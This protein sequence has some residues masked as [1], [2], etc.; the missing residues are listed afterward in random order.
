[1][2]PFLPREEEAGTQVYPVVSSSLEHT[3]VALPVKE[4]GNGEN[5][6]TTA[7]IDKILRM[8]RYFIFGT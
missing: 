5:A 6:V 3:D 4:D 8:A 7:G 1:M 2:L